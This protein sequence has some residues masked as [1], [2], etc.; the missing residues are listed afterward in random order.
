MPGPAPGPGQAPARRPHDPRM[1]GAGGRQQAQPRPVQPSQ[2]APVQPQQSV[3]ANLPAEQQK[4]TLIPSY[5]MHVLTEN[6]QKDAAT[7]H[8]QP[9]LNSKKI[10]SDTFSCR[11]TQVVHDAQ[12]L[13]CL[14]F[15]CFLLGGSPSIAKFGWQ[16]QLMFKV[17][18]WFIAASCS[19]QTVL[20]SCQVAQ[21]E[22]HCVL[23]SATKPNHATLSCPNRW[24]AT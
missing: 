13:S 3:A 19:L 17:S 10:A 9:V 22:C 11:L 23:C 4:G 20:L 14:Q 16:A 21:A 5:N 6:L 15:V 8:N 18:T 2:Q 12:R 1:R 7:S 24:P